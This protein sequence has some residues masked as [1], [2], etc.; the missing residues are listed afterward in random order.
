MKYSKWLL[1][2]SWKLLEQGYHIWT[3]MEELCK[4]ITN[5]S[6]RLLKHLFQA[7]KIKQSNIFERVVLKGCSRHS[8]SES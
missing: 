2:A 5:S 1:W 6:A 8:Y 4:I 3:I 7:N